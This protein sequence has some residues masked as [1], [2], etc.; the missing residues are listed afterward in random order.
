MG[1]LDKY[2][3]KLKDSP[4]QKI[5]FRNHKYFIK[6]DDLLSSDFSGNKAR[7]FYYFF[8][9]DLSDIDVITSYGG[10]QSNAMYSLSAL[11]KI[12]NKKFIYYT[13]PLPKYLKENPL[14]NFKYAI[15]NGMEIIEI[16]NFENIEPNSKT[17]LIKQGGA[18]EYAKYGVKILAKEIEEFARESNLN[19]LSIFLPSGT[20]TT[21]LYLQKYTK[22]KV[23][24]TPCVGDSEYLKSQ[25]LEL[26]KDEKLHPIILNLNKKYHFGKLYKE[27]FEIYKELKKDTNIEFEL[28][29]DPKGWMVVDRFKKELGENILY[30]HSGGVIGNESMIERYKRKYK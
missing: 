8:D 18:E 25:F 10:N 15:Q 9:S 30:I 12:K 3:Q 28:L 1:Y 19:E 14:G 20:G 13:K 21:A 24:T 22:F 11:A 23:Y 17:L 5:T 7:K 6:R 27:F 2:M 26:C 4:I 29:Y 16:D